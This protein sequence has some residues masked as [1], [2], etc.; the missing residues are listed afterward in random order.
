M[1]K[2]MFLT[3]SHMIQGYLLLEVAAMFSV[4]SPL[5]SKRKPDPRC[6]ESWSL[7]HRGEISLVV[8]VAK[9]LILVDQ[10]PWA[11]LT[12]WPTAFKLFIITTPTKHGVHGQKLLVS[13]FFIWLR[14]IHSY[15][16]RGGV[17]KDAQSCRRQFCKVFDGQAWNGKA[18]VLIMAVTSHLPIQRHARWDRQNRCFTMRIITGASE[19]DSLWERIACRKKT[20]YSRDFFGRESYLFRKQSSEIQNEKTAT[21]NV[22]SWFLML[23]LY[24]Q[25]CDVKYST[26]LLM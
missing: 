25:H 6:C 20:A 5:P 14:L 19:T 21:E 13:I 17:C 18:G 11:P 10:V 2:W 23:N 7:T 22:D 16:L 4:H 9:G 8:R 1:V 3:L 15:Q 12:I 24:L 26:V